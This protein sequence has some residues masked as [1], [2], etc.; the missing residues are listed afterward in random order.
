[1][2]KGLNTSVSVKTRLILWARSAGRC[3]LCNRDLIGDLMTGNVD[4]V[5]GLVA[6]IV[7]ESPDGPRGDKFR[8]PLLVD[9]VNNLMLM[10]HG[11]HR[12][13]DDRETRH[14]YPV[15]R[16]LAMKAAHEHRIAVQTS[17]ASDKATNI[18]RFGARIGQNQALLA[19]PDMQNAVLPNRYP[20]VTGSIDLEL[21]GCKYEDHE[22][23]YWRI[24]QENLRRNFQAQVGG[25]IE[26][27]D[28]R[29]YSVF[30]LAPQPLLIELGR[31]L[32]DIVP[33]DVYQRHREPSTWSWPS[34][35]P[36]IEF[37]LRRPHQTKSQIAL[38]LGISS[39]ISD[40]RIVSTLGSEVSIWSV[41]AKGAHNDILKVRSSQENFRALARSILRDIKTAHG[42]AA[43][44]NVFPAMPVALAVELGRIWMPKADLPMT[45]YDQN[46]VSGG[47]IKTL[48]IKSEKT[49]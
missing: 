25:R 4:L 32:S 1:M 11:H 15:E 36:E 19:L 21:V 29:H 45:I 23:Q 17:I 42:E 31:Q 24:Q 37:E 27:N 47:F 20:A 48:E 6:H 44:I 49:L 46:R 10:C 14:K 33:A 41:T 3:H 40:D 8:S 5:R 39:P 22:E 16:L 43:L 13:I 30:A 38:V 26:R 35:G 28:V 9:D 34:D 2:A 12:E 18:V 7:A